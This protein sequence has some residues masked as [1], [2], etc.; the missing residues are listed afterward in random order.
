MAGPTERGRSLSPEAGAAVWRIFGQGAVPG[1]KRSTYE[2]VESVIREQ[3]PPGDQGRAIATAR[4]W[5]ESG[6]SAR[7]LKPD[8][9]EL[10]ADL[11]FEGV[12]PRRS[13]TAL[14]AI[15]SIAPHL[16]AERIRRHWSSGEVQSF[17]DAAIQALNGVSAPPARSSRASREV[18]DADESGFPGVTLG[19]GV[20]EAFA[21][22]EE[23]SLGSANE[24]LHPTVG[25]LIELMVELS[26]ERFE[27]VLEGLQAPAMQ[28]KAARHLAS[29]RAPEHGTP[30][31][32]I[33]DRSCDA[34]IALAIVLALKAAR[35]IDETSAAPISEALPAEPES[36][37]D[38]TQELLL[39]IVERLGGLA[40][41]VCLRW[42]SELLTHAARALPATSDG[43][44][45]LQLR[46][47]EEECTKLAAG[48]FLKR[49]S[50]DLLTQLRSDLGPPRQGLWVGLQ[51]AVAREIRPSSAERSAELAQF[52]FD[53]HRRQLAEHSTRYLP[54]DWGDRNDRDWLEGLGTALA[55][56]QE[57][58]D[59]L[60]WVTTECRS[61]PL[62]VWDAES[63][64]DAFAA[65]EQTV[66][67]WFRVALLAV[68]QR[69]E[70]GLPISPPAVRALAEALWEHCRF[71]R[72][73]LD[74]H[75]EA[76][77]TA[78]LAARYAM[79][80]G[81]ADD[82][83]ILDQ[84]QSNA[85]GPRS[86]WALLEERRRRPR[87]AV[88]AN[89]GYDEMIVAELVRLASEHF[90]DG[91]Q[92]DLENLE[93]W[94]RLWLHLGVVDQAERTAMAIA[95][96]PLRR[97]DRKSRILTL[98]LLGLVVRQRKRSRN[99]R[100]YVVPLYN[101]LWP[102]YAKTPSTEKTDRREI[103]EA[104]AGSEWLLH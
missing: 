95:D 72:Q 97:H 18:D 24:G 63:D 14:W 49:W 77:F 40:P 86:L 99:A 76:S 91:G 28:L 15:G 2:Q 38:A 37:G 10:I 87:Q 1:A 104:L 20:V 84:V 85:V 45:P 16:A 82:Q 34:A 81:D 11:I 7:S 88:E 74:S 100:A 33:T 23:Q 32:W 68:P 19:K 41:P 69:S 48:L 94:G 30:L 22:L 53:E 73:H 59:L 78:E 98:R 67:H 9:A 6:G 35:A 80:F 51:A 46:R 12:G 26:P 54:A 8:C 56:A 39:G 66:R 70:L 64:L 5:F 47:L 65:A 42:I 13:D 62:S 90:G 96:F 101:Q 17:I 89:P 55:L 57:D 71:C 36:F 3:V 4:S 29:Q 61:L 52:I 93:F 21:R 44:K 43:E 25:N 92:F 79:E 83:W 60:A 58:L 31:T 102:H 50:A 27:F 103:D 75:P